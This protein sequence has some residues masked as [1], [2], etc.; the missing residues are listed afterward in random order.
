MSW[1]QFL[2]IVTQNFLNLRKPAPWANFWR[3]ITVFLVNFMT[4]GHEWVTNWWIVIVQ[5][6]ADQFWIHF[7]SV[8]GM[9]RFTLH[10]PTTVLQPKLL[11]WPS[12]ASEL[13]PT[14]LTEMNY[15]RCI[16]GLLNLWKVRGGCA[17][18]IRRWWI[19]LAQCRIL[20]HNFSEAKSPF[21]FGI[22]IIIIMN[23]YID[24]ELISMKE[25]SSRKWCI[26]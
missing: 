22:I 3:L 16:F 11:S 2:A 5:C 14:K 20:Q 4:F 13:L 7:A 21:D 6:I 23:I 10:T 25:L 12:Q 8:R 15:Q 1:S 26:H 9:H 18:R 24:T 17:D 19:G